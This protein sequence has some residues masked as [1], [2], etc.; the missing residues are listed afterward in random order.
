M[1]AKM[2]RLHNRRCAEKPGNLSGMAKKI[3]EN[4]GDIMFAQKKK[5]SKLWLV[6]PV[7]LAMAVG[8]WLNAGLT[9]ENEDEDSIPAGSD[10]YEEDISD[11]AGQPDLSS[12]SG[13]E[14]SGEEG[15]QED[16]GSQTADD[17]RYDRNYDDGT[18]ENG[19]DSSGYGIVGENG[20]EPE[21]GTQN[22][23]SPAS[24]GGSGSEKEYAGKIVVISD[25]DGSISILRY[26]ENGRVTSREKTDIDTA[27][28]T[29]TDQQLFKKGFI[30]NDDSELSELL[31]DFEG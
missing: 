17:D 25:T 4:A 15:W 29:E 11:L 14:V 31:Q 21:S 10:Q 30:L 24:S 5:K 13:Y 3:I 20:Q 26:D 22:D 7:I 16:V 1:A 12:D 9:E 23:S 8:L 27:M 6:I 18:Y 28:L 2:R 19:N